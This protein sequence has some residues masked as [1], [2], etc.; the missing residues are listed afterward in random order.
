MIWHYKSKGWPQY[1][2]D[3]DLINSPIRV[4][5]RAEHKKVLCG[6]GVSLYYRKPKPKQPMEDNEEKSRQQN[7]EQ[8][9]EKIKEQNDE[10]EEEPNMELNEEPGEITEEK[11]KET[12]EEG[13]EE[14]TQK[15]T[16]KEKE[17]SIEEPT[18][19]SGEK[20]EE[21]PGESQ[22]EEHEEELKEKRPEE[23]GQTA[24][25]EAEAGQR[26]STITN[27]VRRWKRIFKRM[28]KVKE[29]NHA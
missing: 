1:S 5:Y 2:S 12:K 14:A 9:F 20:L 25:I 21:E 27:Y 26:V 23:S 22:K 29:K 10:P 24:S 7:D 13:K 19:N 6:G 28:V 3:T 17:E 4:T 11:P 16:G 15:L 18:E 8:N